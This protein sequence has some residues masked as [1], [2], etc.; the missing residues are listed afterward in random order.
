MPYPCN[1]N[2]GWSGYIGRWGLFDGDGTET[3]AWDGAR[4][5][6]NNG[7]GTFEQVS[8]PLLHTSSLGLL[9]SRLLVLAV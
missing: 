1:P 8:A 7:D 5:F 2:R 4:L 6:K 3:K 9:T